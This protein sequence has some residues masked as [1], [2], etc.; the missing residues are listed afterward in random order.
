LLRDRH[1][2][3]ARDMSAPGATRVSVV[4]PAYNEGAWLPGLVSALVDRLADLHDV[5]VEMVVV[6]D[7]SDAAD[8]AASRAATEAA[9]ATLRARG[10]GHTFQFV[11]AARNGGKGSAIRLGWQHVAPDAE[12]MGWLDA[13]G[14]VSAAECLRLVALLRDEPAADV[15]AGSR[16]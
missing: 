7:G 10:M 12:W 16:V 1:G 3:A 4:I 15:V 8:S 2:R 5:R 6:D 9:A 11:R 14:A 13:D